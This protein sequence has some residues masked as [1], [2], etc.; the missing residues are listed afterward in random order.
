MT[1]TAL[2]CYRT[3]KAGKVGLTELAIVEVIKANQGCNQS[4]IANI[5]GFESGK[6]RTN[7][8][9]CY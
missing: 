1:M 3:V 9:M 2:E 5:M 6:N 4:T 7:I 8:Q